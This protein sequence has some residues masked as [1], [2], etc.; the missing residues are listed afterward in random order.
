MTIDIWSGGTYPANV[1]SNFYPNAFVFDG[2]ECSSMEGLLQSLKTKNVALQK[3]V[4]SCSDRTAKFFFRHRVQNI[5]WKLTGKLYWKGKSI[6]RHGDEYQCFLDAI[7]DSICSNVS[8]REALITSN[9]AEL[10]HKLGGKDTR[11]T[12]LTEYE[13]VS[14]LMR[15]REMV[16]NQRENNLP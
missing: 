7:Y 2:V 8:F 16:V 3:T 1:L 12:I 5:R 9:G 6:N 15:C 13:F 4:C 14:R 10:T 11:K